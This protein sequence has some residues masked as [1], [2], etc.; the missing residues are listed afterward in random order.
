MHDF[1]KGAIA[2]KNRTDHK[3]RRSGFTRKF[4]RC[5]ASAACVLG[6]AAVCFGV[7]GYQNKIKADSNPEITRGVLDGIEEVPETKKTMFKKNSDDYMHT[8]GTKENPFMILEIVPYEEYASFGY[9]ISGCEP[10]D[11]SK[12]YG[13]KD[14]MSLAASMKTA[15]ADLQSGTFFFPDEPEANPDYYTGD[16]PREYW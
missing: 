5:L 15:T 3:K 13:N 14:A 2:L 10:V 4:K 16:K 9:H 6:V 1:K 7:A 11:F 12:N 8:L